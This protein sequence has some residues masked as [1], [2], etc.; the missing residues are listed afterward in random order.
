MKFSLSKLF[1]AIVSILLCQYLCSTFVDAATT[2]SIV[3]TSTRDGN[4]EIYVMNSDGS[5]EI[6]LTRNR[7]DD[8]DPAWS[9]DGKQIL[10]V[11]DRDGVRDLYLMDADGKNIQRV[12]GKKAHREQPAWSPDG[13]MIVY[14]EPEEHALMTY[15]IRGGSEKRLGWIDRKRGH[16]AWS[17]DGTE[18]AYDWAG[19]ASIRLINLKTDTITVLLPNRKFAMW[20]PAWAPTGNRVV[21]AGLKWPK[22]HVG[23]LRID[24]KMTLYVADRGGAWVKEIV[25]EPVVSHPTWSPDGSEILYEKPVD[26]RRQLFKVDS[27]RGKPQ[28]LTRSGTNYMADWINSP[29]LS[30]EPTSSSL[31]TV[32]GKMT[33]K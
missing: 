28:Q 21:F 8:F 33:R 23:P 20:H 19:S 25:K 12:F 4:K 2:A 31:T 26:N 14:I 18:I 9:P 1:F 29:G 16:P 22:N 5:R 27:E 10:F 6:N 13:K 3:F 32:W 11:S 7:A 17:P 15:S 24:D 30:V